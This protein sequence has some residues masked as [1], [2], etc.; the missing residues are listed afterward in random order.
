MDKENLYYVVK[1][2][3][4]ERTTTMLK[5]PWIGTLIAAEKEIRSFWSKYCNY[6]PISI[7]EYENKFTE[8]NKTIE[9][10]ELLTKN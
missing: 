6:E 9:K 3:T 8:Q 1:K 2:D 7:K 5:E 10:V 4:N